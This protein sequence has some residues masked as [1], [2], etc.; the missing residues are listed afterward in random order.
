MCCVPAMVTL[1][2]MLSVEV[3]T[4]LSGLQLFGNLAGLSHL[5]HE[6]QRRDHRR[7]MQLSHTS[8][9]CAHDIPQSAA[10]L[11]AQKAAVCC[12]RPAHVIDSRSAYLQSSRVAHITSRSRLQGHCSGRSTLEV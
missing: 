5:C 2:L 4:P 6:R 10:G 7:R 12:V 1:V 11:L 8:W 9:G 3:G